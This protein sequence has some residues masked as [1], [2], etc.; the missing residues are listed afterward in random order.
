MNDDTKT[1]RGSNDARGATETSDSS[2]VSSSQPDVASASSATP[3]FL[4]QALEASCLCEICR[5]PYQAAVT[6]AVRGCGHSFC[7]RCIRKTFAE[8]AS[9][10]TRK[11]YC[12][13]CRTEVVNPNS[14]STLLPNRALQEVVHEVQQAQAQLEK[15]WSRRHRHHHHQEKEVKVAPASSDPLVSTAA[16]GSRRSS[17]R[18]KSTAAT[19]DYTEEDDDEVMVLEEEDEEEQQRRK[20]QDSA[21]LLRSKKSSISFKG[22]N[23]KKLAELCTKEGL[24]SH[25]TDD[26]LKRR[27]KEY[28]MLYNA[29]CDAIYPKSKHELV[30]E[31]LAQERQVKLE[32][33]AMSYQGKRMMTASS[34]SSGSSKSERGQL[35]DTLLLELKEREEK[36]PK[37]GGE[38]GYNFYKA[39]ASVN[40]A[41]S[42]KAKSDSDHQK[43]VAA[44]APST[45][46]NAGGAA[47]AAV[48]C[49]SSTSY[50]NVDSSFE[51]TMSSFSVPSP[52]TNVTTNSA[53]GSRSEAAID[54]DAMISA[55]SASKK[56][57]TTATTTPASR[58]R[59]ARQARLPL[60]AAAATSS[61]MTP[62]SSIISTTMGSSGNKRSI[63]GNWTCPVCTFENLNRKHTTARCEM[64]ERPRPTAAM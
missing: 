1:H 47:A 39:C 32:K 18:A 16:T 20:E 44:A 60:T 21:P 26:V 50:P 40:V 8:Q 46:M 48:T 34:S 43:Q 19:V 4:L 62:S 6:I 61:N 33:S 38:G 12:P 55:T 51:S 45:E 37:R 52:T 36:A 15:S 30:Q 24:P 35:F 53:I 2:A 25:G 42:A 49:E 29:N 63:S 56:K 57:T 9:K 23:R 13:K 5:C 11:T 14:E 3:T 27:L 59:K 58:K 31:L 22:K 17:R 64:C 41:N 28:I 54:V 10:V 7:S